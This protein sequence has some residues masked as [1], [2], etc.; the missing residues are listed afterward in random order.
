MKHLNLT[1]LCINLIISTSA[2]ATH[3]RAGEIRV[4]QLSDYTLE[5]TVIT[6][7]KESSFAADRDSIVIDWGDGTFSKVVRSN[8]FGESLG[9]DVKKNTYVATHDYAGRGTYIIGFFDPNRISD[10]VNLDPP[11]SVNIPFYVQTVFT[12]LNP[13]FQGYNQTVE[14]VQYPIDF[15]CLNQVFVH[16]PAAN[17]PDSDSLAFVL[18]TPL[19]DKNSPAPNY[20]LPSQIKPGLDNQL[21]LDPKTGTIIWNSPKQP[22]EY[23][24]S[25]IVQE[26]RAGVLIAST[27]RD[28]QILVRDDCKN[29][30]PPTIAGVTDTCILVGTPMDIKFRISDPDT[31][32][33]SKRVKLVY[34]GSAFGLNNP[35]MITAPSSYQDTSFVARFQWTPDCN[36]VSNNYYVFV[37]KAT[38]NFLDS[39]GAVDIHTFRVK[40]IAPSPDN[41]SLNSEQGRNILTWNFPYLCDQATEFRG[42][43]IWRSERS[44]NILQD[45]CNPDLSVFSYKQIA[46]SVEEISGSTYVYKDTSITS[47]ST[48]C[49]RI[50][51]EYSKLS[52][53]NFPYNFTHS[54]SSNEVCYFQ[55][56]NSPSITMVDIAKTNSSTGEII[57]QWKNYFLSSLDTSNFEPPYEQSIEEKYPNQQWIKVPGSFKQYNSRNEIWDSSFVLNNTNTLSLQHELRVSVKDQNSKTVYSN[58][59]Q[60][61]FLNAITGDSNINLQWQELV[62]WQNI[63]YEVFKKDPGSSIF[64][65]ITETNKQNYIDNNV[66]LDSQ[67]CYY[68]RSTGIFRISNIQD[69]TFNRSN[70]NCIYA[71]DNRPPCCAQLK[72]S[73]PCDEIDEH[74]P[75]FVVKLDWDNPNNSCPKKSASLIRLY[76]VDILSAQLIDSM[77]F[78]ISHT[79]GYV[80]PINSTRPACYKIASF[81]ANGMS[82]TQESALC[83]DLCFKYELPNSFTPNGDHYNDLFVPTQNLF[84]QSVDFKVLNQWGGLVFETQDPEINWDGKNKNGK[85]L[86][87]GTYYYTCHINPY[88]NVSTS[89][90]KL[91]LSGFIELLHQ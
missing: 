73:E 86:A 21:S 72:L 59:A 31:A 56:E 12:I 83:P 81:D 84:V 3:N 62:P 91:N 74:K 23:N 69:S 88:Y 79:G 24:L 39:T 45:T 16:N 67:Y 54:L 10:I 13:A 68:I 51:A 27:I 4:K 64:K 30:Q 49:Y 85:L 25:F 43:S 76:K 8:Q 55:N 42:F 15:A 38:D 1:I 37:L 28:M 22:G 58:P 44:K 9:N 41:L 14:L 29:N 57:I 32:I 46:Y 70:I 90:Q 47:T 18:S 35:P 87:S 65:K 63:S 20:S 26:W 50:Q 53:Q 89:K 75:S 60:S 66:T 48:Y 5:A 11:N 34:S 36:H 33:G 82:C 71:K 80:D 52:T 17:D 40:V 2:L 78:D 61:I 7:T 19:M 6:F 77:D